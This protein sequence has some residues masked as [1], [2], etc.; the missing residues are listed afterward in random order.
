[1]RVGKINVPATM[2]DRVETFSPVSGRM[3]SVRSTSTGAA[4]ARLMAFTRFAL[5]VIVSVGVVACSIFG[6]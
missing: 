5:G 4:R 6:W 1:M 2:R 3:Y